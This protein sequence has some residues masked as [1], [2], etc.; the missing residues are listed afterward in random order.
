[1]LTFY[2][3]DGDLQCNKGFFTDCNIGTKLLLTFRKVMYL[4]FLQADRGNITSYFS[5]FYTSTS[6]CFLSVVEH[7]LVGSPQ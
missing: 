4:L 7:T 2:K 5:G 6:A 1:M 3:K